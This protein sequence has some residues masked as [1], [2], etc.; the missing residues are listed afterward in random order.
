MLPEIFYAYTCILFNANGSILYT[1][2]FTSLSF[3]YYYFK[4]NPAS[5]Q[6]ELEALQ[7]NTYKIMVQKVRL[8]KK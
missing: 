8:E 7:H 3:Y 6:G 4:N 1:P 5:L 2:F